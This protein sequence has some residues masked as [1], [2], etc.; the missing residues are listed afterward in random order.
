M[1]KT[2]S[3]VFKRAS[4]PLSSLIYM[5]CA[6]QIIEQELGQSQWQKIELE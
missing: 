6:P 3:F 1:G 5:I 2:L 4:L